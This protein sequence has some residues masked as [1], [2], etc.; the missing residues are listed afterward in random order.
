MA[1]A[2][3]AAAAA[4]EERD[5]Q[6]LCNARAVQ[7]AGAEPEELAEL[8]AVHQEAEGRHE[9]ACSGEG[10]A[11][12][13]DNELARAAHAAA[14]AAGVE[15]KERART[16]AVA[17]R[18]ALAIRAA[19]PNTFWD[20]GAAVDSVTDLQ[21]VHALA[22]KF[23][24]GGTAIAINVVRD[25]GGGGRSFVICTGH[26][27][28]AG[29]MYIVKLFKEY[30]GRECIELWKA[31]FD[32][33]NSNVPAAA[34][35]ISA[36]APAAAAAAPVQPAAA[37]RQQMQAVPVP[38]AGAQPAPLAKAP[39]GGARRVSATVVAAAATVAAAAAATVAAA[40]AATVAAAAAAAPMEFE[41]R[42]RIKDR[43]RRYCAAEPG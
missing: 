23:V 34:A 38:R 11:K 41:R 35:P 29:N 15:E 14:A 9:R 13:A 8:Q 20:N 33:A 19:P 6:D 10:T 26:G 4:A 21:A 37:T 31:H 5:M 39:G 32:L 7:E 27:P 22:Q 17:R 42:R 30:L 28:A 24:K 25:T 1:A 2:A 18:G 43:R 40:A 36:A 16:D 3:A 12:G